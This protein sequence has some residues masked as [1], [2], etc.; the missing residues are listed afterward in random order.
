MAAVCISPADV[1]SRPASCLVNFLLQGRA[2]TLEPLNRSKT[3]SYVLANHKGVIYLHC[4]TSSVGRSFLEDPPSISEGC[5]GRVTDYRINDFG[6][7]MRSCQLAPP[8][9]L[10]GTEQSNATQ[11][12]MHRLNTLTR[13]WPLVISETILFNIPEECEPLLSLLKKPEMTDDEVSLCKKTVYRLIEKESN[14]EYL[15]LPGMNIR[16]RG[17]PK[18]EELYRQLWTELQLFV[19]EFSHMSP[20]HEQVCRFV[21]DLKVVDT[22]SHSAPTSAEGS[23]TPSTDWPHDG[24]RSQQDNGD[25]NPAKKPRYSLQHGPTKSQASKTNYVHIISGSSKSLSLL[26]VCQKHGKLTSLSRTEFYRREKEGD[27]AKLYP[28]LEVDESKH[29]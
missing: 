1:T 27:T 20:K 24:P 22:E 9:P 4:C 12:A 8:P 23:W 28:N 6:D 11:L 14:N 2:V 13:Y 29:F 19:E 26:E 17:G 16:G 5:G 10:P 3:L 18:R 7:L 21:K 25:M 15:S